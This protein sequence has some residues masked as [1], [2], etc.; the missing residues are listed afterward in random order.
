MNLLKNNS[1][2]VIFTFGIIVALSVILTI[3]FMTQ[4]AHVHVIY[5]MDEDGEIEILKDSTSQL[6]SYTLTNQ[7]LASYL[8]S[9][10]KMP[11]P[12]DGLT[13]DEAKETIYSFQQSMNGM[14]NFILACL[15]VG[16]CMFAGLLIF[17]NNSR[18]V[19]YKSNLIAGIVAPSVVCIMSIVAII[20]DILLI[21]NFN[22]NSDLYKMTAVMENFDIAAIDKLQMR[23]TMEFQTV[24]DNYASGVNTATLVVTLIYFIVVIA[25]AGVVVAHTL[26]KYKNTTARRE[27]IIKRAMVTE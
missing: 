9:T 15:V 20:W 1:K 21:S 19:Y 16:L 3:S 7:Y 13:F 5:T 17:S 23:Q 4:Y 25:S 6:G 26:L 18:S 24:I 12:L 8:N 10:T 2:L 11:G 22:A 27:E 14:N